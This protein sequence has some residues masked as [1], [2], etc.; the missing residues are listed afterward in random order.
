MSLNRVWIP[1]PCYSSRGGQSVRLIVLHTAEGATT[2]ESLGNWF[3]NS[4]NQVSSHTGAD[5]K[6]N[7]VGEYVRRDNKAWT[8]SNANP[9]AVQIEMC[10]FAKWSADEWAQHPNMLANCAAW[11]AEEAAHYGIPIRALSSSEA[12]GG[13]TGVCQ[14]ADLGSWGGGHWDCGGGFPMDQVLQMAGGVPGPGPAPTPP[15]PGG[16]APPFPYPP[17]DYLGQARPDPHCHS[18]YYASDRP[19][20]ATWQGQMAARGWSIGVDGQYGP[21]SEG[22]ARQFQQEKGLAVDGLVGPQTWSTSWTAPVT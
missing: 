22:V 2:I 3:A 4:A 15:Q 1:S 11:V 8:S 6:V 16:P 21:Q 10:A 9:V 7:T 17:Q 19:N 18:G 5:D 20:V 13:G 14:H 12:Q